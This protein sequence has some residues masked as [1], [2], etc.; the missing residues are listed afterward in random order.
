MNTTNTN[1]RLT[2]S[3]NGYTIFELFASLF[4]IGFFVFTA[5]VM[6][7][8]IIKG[9]G[10]FGPEY[11]VKNAT[12]NRLYVDRSSESSHYMVGTD[13]GVF[14]VDNS[15]FMNIYNADEIYSSIQE[16]KTY[17]FDVEGNKY[18]GLLGQHYP[19]IKRVYV[20]GEQ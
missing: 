8:P 3:R 2:N 14:E 12:V 1:N 9:V 10:V 13:K 18:I 7:I 19:Y 20:V 5:F 16:G 15:V 11:S 4:V 6:L 17:T